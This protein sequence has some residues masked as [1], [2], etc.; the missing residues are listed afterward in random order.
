MG[1]ASEKP[2]VRHSK[3]V[4][5][6]Q[7]VCLTQYSSIAENADRFPVVCTHVAIEGIT[8]NCAAA[9]NARSPLVCYPHSTVNCLKFGHCIHDETELASFRLQFVF[10]AR[11]LLSYYMQIDSLT[12]YGSLI[13]LRSFNARSSFRPLSISRLSDKEMNFLSRSVCGDGGNF[14]AIEEVSPETAT[15]VRYECIIL[16]GQ[17]F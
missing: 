13:R 1:N 6:S 9:V 11:Q 16:I 17:I 5:R 15:H 8:R 3:S 12:C 7:S 14:N 2:R 4:L 10:I